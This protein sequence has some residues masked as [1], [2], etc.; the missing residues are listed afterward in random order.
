[1]LPLGQG[2]RTAALFLLTKVV[3]KMRV[4]VLF[5]GQ[6]SQDPKIFADDTLWDSWRHEWGLL[7]SSSPV[8]KEDILAQLNSTAV[9]QPAIVGYS[10]HAFKTL[11]PLL[12]ENGHD[13]TALAGHSLGEL[14]ATAVSLNW[15]V[16]RAM[17]LAQCRGKLMQQVCD[18]FGQKVGMQAWIGRAINK[19]AIREL[20]ARKTNLWFLNDNSPGQVVIGGVLQHFTSEDLSSCSVAKVI[21]LPVSV[22]SHCPLFE[23]MLPSWRTALSLAPWGELTYPI[24]NHTNLNSL[25]DPSDAYDNLGQQLTQE[26]R[27]QDMIEKLSLTTDLFIEVGPS[28]ILKSLVGKITTTRCLSLSEALIELATNNNSSPVRSS[29]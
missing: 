6:G 13:I 2:L 20:L 25:Q 28:Q 4:V 14:T 12:K 17:G 8:C 27:F 19:S 24:V 1:M 5:P 9:T 26:V 21:T 3:K 7:Q 29:L 18:D 15:G 22:I 23:T 11:Q 10:Y 16:E